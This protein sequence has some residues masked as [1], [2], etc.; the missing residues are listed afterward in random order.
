MAAVSIVKMLAAA[1]FCSLTIQRFTLFFL[2][3]SHVIYLHLN[4]EGAF[5]NTLH[6]APITAPSQVEDNIEWFIE[7]P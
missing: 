3:Y 5:V 4:R 6:T 1:F 7:R 2:E